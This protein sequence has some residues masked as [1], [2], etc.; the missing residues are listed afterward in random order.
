MSKE[1]RSADELKESLGNAFEVQEV[2]GKM[3]I[4]HIKART[5]LAE[6][7]PVAKE[8]RVA[9][10]ASFADQPDLEGKDLEEAGREALRP[11]IR[12]YKAHGYREESLEKRP[13]QV[14]EAYDGNDVPVTVVYMERELQDG[15]D[16]R[17]EVAWLVEQLPE[18]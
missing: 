17:E 13:A 4:D 14:E 12:D 10:M 3:V 7:D 15:E 9:L 16:L 11:R 6:Y 2:D 18:R 5:Y 8:I 1:D